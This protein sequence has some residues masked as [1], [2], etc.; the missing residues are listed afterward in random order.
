MPF[1]TSLF[2]V[3]LNPYLFSDFFSLIIQLETDLF[4]CPFSSIIFCSYILRCYWIH[5][6]YQLF[7]R[8]ELK[9]CHYELTFSFSGNAF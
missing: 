2:M 3:F 6:H 7:F 1:G 8:G 5:T 9:L 4:T